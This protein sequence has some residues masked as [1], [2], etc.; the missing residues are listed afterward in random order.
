MG[1]LDS[2][3]NLG[4][5]IGTETG[6]ISKEQKKI[7]QGKAENDN[8]PPDILRKLRRLEESAL[9]N[10]DAEKMLDIGNLY[11]NGKEIGYDPDKALE[12]WYRSAELGEALAQY[13]I[14]LL[15]HINPVYENSKIAG[16][17][18]EKSAR[19]GYS[20]ARQKLSEYYQYSKLLKKWIRTK[21]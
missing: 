10:N 6:K 3:V 11:I 17:W 20:P 8:L 16:E 12:W 21:E 9:R 13:N 1:F 4:V 19:N 5:D 15:H 7:K 2:I 18:F 14:G